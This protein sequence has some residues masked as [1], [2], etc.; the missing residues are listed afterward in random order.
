M[1]DRVRQARDAA[2]TTL[3]RVTAQ[4]SYAL[5]RAVT[6]EGSTRTALGAGHPDGDRIIL[7]ATKT[8]E[9]LQRARGAAEAAM[10]ELRELDV[11]AAA[12]GAP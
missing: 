8:I 1:D 4:C 9:C 7:D 3:N 12:N 5:S 10:A 6:A 2:V 11:D